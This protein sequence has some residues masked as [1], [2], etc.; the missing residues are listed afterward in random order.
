MKEACQNILTAFFLIGPDGFEHVCGSK[1][2]YKHV[3]PKFC[4]HRYPPKFLKTPAPSQIFKF[5]W[6]IADKQAYME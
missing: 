6:H 2:L 1:I 4:T 5:A 3:V